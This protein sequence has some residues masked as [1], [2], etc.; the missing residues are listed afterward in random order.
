V[1]SRELQGG[2][3]HF[4]ATYRLH[5]QEENIFLR[6]LGKRVKTARHH[7]PKDRDRQLIAIADRE[8]LIFKFG[9]DLLVAIDILH[10]T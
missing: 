4:G 7:D 3:Q 5:L 9:G 8:P 2:Y 6:K 10:V 1:T